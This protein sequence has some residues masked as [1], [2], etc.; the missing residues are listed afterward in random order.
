MNKRKASKVYKVSD[1]EFKEIIA[2][3]YSYSD[4][5]RALGLKTRGGSST[6][7]LKQRIKELN[8]SI[9]HFNRG[10]NSSTYKKYT[11]DEI[12]VENSLYTNTANLKKRLVKE[13]IL[14]YKCAC[15]G[16]SDWLDKPIVL[17][18]DH[19]NGNNKDNRIN[20]LRL[21]C[22]N[23]HSQTD[24]YAGKNAIR[25]KQP[26]SYCVLC[27]KELKT[28]AIHCV[29]CDRFLRRKVERP[30]RQELKQMIRTIPFTKIGSMYNI[31]DSSIR[32]W[33]DSY[34]LPRTKKE[35]NSYSDEEWEGI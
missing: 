25:Y 21:L 13:G 19:I 2:N 8:C 10:K 28:N 5:L 17:Q 29:E 31:N 18:L 30:T 4:C 20:N 6:D 9:E 7:L 22:P 26:I 32:K 12:L 34:N 35:I 11:T 16:I 33:C 14:Q 15:C 1:D 27:G 24:T 3:N 23:C